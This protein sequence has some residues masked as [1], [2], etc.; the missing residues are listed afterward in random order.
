MLQASFKNET[1]VLIF[2]D[3]S[4]EDLIITLHYKLENDDNFHKVDLRTTKC[5]DDKA[6]EYRVECIIPDAK[7]GKY[8]CK[9]QSKCDFGT[10]EMSNEKLVSKGSKVNTFLV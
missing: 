7:T 2:N 10:S 9:I 6:N 8:T 1:L 5:A 3:D 4:N